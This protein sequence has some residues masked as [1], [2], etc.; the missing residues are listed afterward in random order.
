[1]APRAWGAAVS[2]SR[3]LVVEFPG[4]GLT[5]ADW[6]RDHAGATVDLISEPVR[7][8]GAD[9][10]HPSV[11]LV[12]GAGR[13]ALVQLMDRLDRLYGPVETLRLEPARGQWLA[14]L[15]VR[16][17][18][19]HSAAAAAVLQFQHRY[20]A[21]WTHIDDGI[22]Y[23]RALLPPREDGDRLAQQMRGYLAQNKVDAQVSVQEFSAHDYGV[24]DD[25]V[26]HAIGL[27]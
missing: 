14:R 25:L 5:L 19:M 6:T 23:M 2:E 11:V 3:F 4:D 18:A 24:W 7:S 13:A 15:S 21:P 26:Q 22:V 27:A 8:R 9:R 10:V 20:G 1:M 17:S 16:E 12:K